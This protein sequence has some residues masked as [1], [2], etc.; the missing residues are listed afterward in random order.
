MGKDMHCFGAALH[1][2]LGWIKFSSSVFPGP[3]TPALFLPFCLSL[4]GMLTGLRL[5]GD[6]IH[7]L[8]PLSIQSD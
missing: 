5:F 8:Y 3:R 2:G 1:D 7:L 4:V 6:E